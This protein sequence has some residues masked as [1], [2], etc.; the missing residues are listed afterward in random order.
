MES[1]VGELLPTVALPGGGVNLDFKYSCLTF[2]ST[3][4]IQ[5]VA[6]AYIDDRLLVAVPHSAWHRRTASKRAFPALTKATLVEVDCME[7]EDRSQQLQP[8]QTVKLWMGFLN[9]EMAAMMT[10]DGEEGDF[11]H[12]FSGPDLDSFYPSGEGLVAAAMEHFAFQSATAGETEEMLDEPHGVSGSHRL[13]SRL[14]RL[15]ALVGNLASKLDRALSSSVVPEAPKTTR[16]SALRRDATQKPAVQP[17]VSF[18]SLD[19]SVVA[20]ALSAGVDPKSLEEMQRLMMEPGVKGKRASE[21]MVANP[22]PAPASTRNSRQ[23]NVL[24]ETDSETEGQGGGSGGATPAGGSASPM[25]DAVSQLAQIVQVLTADRVKKQKA[26]KVEAAL[27]G[28]SPSTVSESGSIGSGKKTATARRALR[29]ALQENEIV[30]LIERLMME[31][32]SSQTVTPGQPLPALC[33]KAWVEHRSKIGHWKSS[34]YTS[35]TVA[36]AL[37]A[38]R[39]GNVQGC[40]ARLNLMLLMLDQTACDKGSWTLSSELSLEQGP[41]MSVLQTHNP[42]SVQDGEWPFSKLLD[43]RWAEVAMSHVKDTEEYVARRSKLGK[44]DGAAEIEPIPKPRPKPK[45]K[46]GGGQPAS[47]VTD[48]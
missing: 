20:S 47:P 43:A 2:N 35:W 7:E 11:S 29:A 5:T 41:P 42:P 44:K 33:A 28:V 22:K 6:V 46:G 27:D 37:D 32:L 31:D 45:P 26:S 10:E 16:P 21:P 8:E 18:P 15:E 48:A 30:N 23:V 12:T 36:A 14:G 25:E 40:R 38:L 19:P 17:H 39:A 1:T 34:A 24:S 4:R 9:A 3:T 13:E